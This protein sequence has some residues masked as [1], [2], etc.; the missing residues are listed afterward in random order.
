M[1]ERGEGEEAEVKVK[2]A[3]WDGPESWVRLSFNPEL[4]SFLTQN[5]ANPDSSTLA[6]RTL[7]ESPVQLPS[8][9]LALRQSIFDS[10]GDGRHTSEGNL[11][12]QARVTIKVPLTT[13]VFDAHFRSV[14]L[15]GIP[16][17][18]GNVSCHVRGDDLTQ[19]L[20]SGWASRAYTTSTV[21]YINFKELIHLQ[22]GYKARS[23]F[24]HTSCARYIRQKTHS[25]LGVIIFIYIKA[26]KQQL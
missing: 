16:S 23:T 5:R 26:P 13:A 3:K 2:W 21:V 7:G 9:L 6:H 11:G 19:V 1:E 4:A 18:H 8:E 24:D 10:L 20:G 25:P 14:D 15:L 22:W 12:R 17:G